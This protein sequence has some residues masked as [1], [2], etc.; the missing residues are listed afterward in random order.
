[1][2]TF[3][4]ASM[5]A[6]FLATLAIA[7]GCEDSPVAIGKDFRI[8]LLANPSTVDVDPQNPPDPPPTSTIIA[9]VV[10]DTGVPQK[11]VN[12]YFTTTSGTLASNTQ[13]VTT[14]SNGNA[15]DVLTVAIVG[16]AETTVTATATSLTESV[17]ITKTG[18]PCA[19][20]TAPIAR[21]TPTTLPAIPAGEIDTSYDT[22][23][24]SGST[25]SDPGGGIASY[26]WTCFEGDNPSTGVE[27]ICTYVYD[28]VPRSYTIELVVTDNGI[29][30]DPDC[31]LSSSPASLT[32]DMP[33]G[34]APAQ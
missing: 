34:T 6:A 14:D 26:S 31:A 27:V 32:I 13:P 23:L 9:T 19:A 12:V 10:N 30:G 25:S 7:T 17:K 2:R 24:L 8:Y 29:A 16:P 21:I 5:F 18:G 1:M 4:K 11:G 20:N 22:P 15:Y 28:D 3:M 33:A